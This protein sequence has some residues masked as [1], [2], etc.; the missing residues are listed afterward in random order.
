MLRSAFSA[1]ALV[2]LASSL[3]AQR[4]DGEW[5]KVKVVANGVKLS[6]FDPEADVSRAKAR[7]TAWIGFAAIEE[8][9]GGAEGELVDL[10]EGTGF[11]YRMTVVT[12]QVEDGY[13]IAS[14]TLITLGAEERLGGF[15][16]VAFETPEAFLSAQ[17]LLQMRSKLKNDELKSASLRSRTATMSNAGVRVD[18]VLVP[19]LG[20]LRFKGKRVKKLEKLPFDPQTVEFPVCIA[21]LTA[22]GTDTG[23]TTDNG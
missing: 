19:L 9:E 20:D 17:V 3:T 2:I 1:L 7:M 16:P 18:E 12:E 5:F 10:F 14:E 15:A 4:F 6:A 13:F 8:S 23:Q 11:L 22:P 21:C